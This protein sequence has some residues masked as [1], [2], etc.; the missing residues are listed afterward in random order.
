MN[1]RDW[2]VPYHIL[3]TQPPSCLTERYLCRRLARLQNLKQ[4]IFLIESTLNICL[5]TSYAKTVEC[6]MQMGKAESFP[7]HVRCRQSCHKGYWNAISTNHRSCWKWLNAMKNIWIAKS[8][9]LWEYR[10]N[11]QTHPMDYVR[12]HFPL[13]QRIF[14][15]IWRK[16]LKQC[17]QMQSNI[18]RW[19]I[20]T[21]F[22]P[23]SQY[24]EKKRVTD[25]TDNFGMLW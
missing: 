15:T 3:L 24:I 17:R 8:C 2:N 11:A 6:V 13:F 25:L 16:Y 14:W 19:I 1:R 4:K 5:T 23:Y 21:V 12:L 7:R 18:M 9:W 20:E 10:K 22:T